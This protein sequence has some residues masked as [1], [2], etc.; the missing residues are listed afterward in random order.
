MQTFDEAAKDI[1]LEV[2]NL[3]ASKQKDY[4]PNNILKS[5]VDPQTAIA[6]RISDKMARWVNL[7]NT[8]ATP[9]NESLRDT[10]MDI[11]GYAL[12]AM[13]VLDGTFTL[14]LEDRN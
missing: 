9:E 12:I 14:P 11:M 8:G 6:V 2:A 13:M 4:G 10:V 7:V 5:I 1:A 3:V